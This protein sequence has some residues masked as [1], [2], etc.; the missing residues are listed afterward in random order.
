[1]A[2][3]R[4]SSGVAKAVFNGVDGHGHEVAYLHFQFALV[5]LEFF[6]RHIGLGLQTGIDNHVVVVDADHFSSDHFASAHFGALQGFFEQGGKRFR[7][8]GCGKAPRG[9]S[10]LNLNGNAP[11]RRERA[12]E[13]RFQL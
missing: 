3:S 13:G 5:V 9:L 6:Q 2:L 1:L 11:M 10:F 7:H 12:V 8:F 4:L